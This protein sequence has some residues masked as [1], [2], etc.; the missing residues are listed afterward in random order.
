MTKLNEEL[1]ARLER[2]AEREGVELLAIEVAGVARRPTVRLILDHEDGGVTIDECE[3]VSRQ[4]SLILD[5]YDPFPGSYNLEV[6]SPGLDRKLYRAAD[7]ERYAGQP[8]RVRMK[9]TWTGKRIV[10]GILEGLADGHLTLRDGEGTRSS[11]PENE[12]FETRLAPFPK[13]KSPRKR[14]GR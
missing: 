3:R 8:V 11:L 6:S 14:G 12:I 5:A 13:E 10:E 4:A 9:P 7:Y 2:L 1:M